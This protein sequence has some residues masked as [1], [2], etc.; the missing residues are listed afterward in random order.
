MRSPAG[1][2]PELSVILATDNFERVRHVVERLGA[3]TISK[4]IEL[5]LV[6]SSPD[7]VKA[8]TTLNDTFH[9]IIVV[10][11]DTVAPLSMS[12]AAGVRASS[13]PYIFIAET[14]AYPDPELAEK[15]VALLAEGWS[16][17]VPGIRNANPRNRLSWAGFLSDYGAWSRT[18]P[19]G[20]IQRAPAHNI[21]FRREVLTDFGDRL[22][23]AFG[24][25]DDL[26]LGLKSR[27]QRIWF[28][29]VPG[30][31][32]VNIDRLGHWVRERFTSGTVIGGTRS[33]G[34]TWKRRLLYICASPLIPFVILAR[35]RR[36]V[37]EVARRET[38]PAGTIAAIVGGAFLKIAGEATGY[39]RGPSKEYENRMTAYEIKKLALNSGEEN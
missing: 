16:V 23:Q 1:N 8:H 6:T 27:G 5:V 26:F 19:A 14:H 7:E 15:I 22:E 24:F 4:K 37:Q 33:K 35:V 20:E 2:G 39:A 31:E 3:Q 29:P 38:L 18:L 21:G 13:G 12:R 36:G 25:G 9:S 34:W 28:E 32:H 10:P 30:I 11:L 17:V